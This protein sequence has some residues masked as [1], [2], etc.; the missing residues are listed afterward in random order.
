MAL[1]NELDQEHV[2]HK[3]M[4]MIRYVGTQNNTAMSAE[5]KE[6]ELKWEEGD[7]EE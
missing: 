7:G 2:V 3:M 5:I 4:V 6:L 1:E